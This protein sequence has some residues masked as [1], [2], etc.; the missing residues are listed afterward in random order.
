M[1]EVT[2]EKAP[3]VVRETLS[4]VGIPD[5]K[6]KVLYPSVY[7]VEQDGKSFLIHFKEWFLINRPTAFNNISEDDKTRLKYVAGLLKKWGLIQ[8]GEDDHINDIPQTMSFK[9]LRKA[10]VVVGE[11]EDK[12]KWTIVHKIRF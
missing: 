12:A 11:N 1:I 2:L 5:E 6:R 7:L 4:R 10:D 8:V 3:N 9:A